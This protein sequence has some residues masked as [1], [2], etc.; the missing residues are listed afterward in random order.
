MEKTKYAGVYFK[1]GK[2]DTTYYIRYK[3]YQETKTEKVGTKL[4]GMTEA[5]AKRILDERKLNIVK[6]G[7]TPKK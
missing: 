2:K 5:K 1:V 3:Q 7:M 6:G 4:A